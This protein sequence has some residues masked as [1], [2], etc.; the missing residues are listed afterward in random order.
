MKHRLWGLA[1]AGF[2]LLGTSG[3]QAADQTAIR[4][5]FTHTER[6]TD[7]VI[8][9]TRFLID[10]AQRRVRGVESGKDFADIRIED[11][12]IGFSTQE[13]G[14][15]VE[16]YAINRMTGL[17]EYRAVE[18][19]TWS[20]TCSEAAKTTIRANSRRGRSPGGS[21]SRREL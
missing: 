5:V 1:L 7:P 2:S 9:P 4:C 8:A 17:L 16:R 3:V 10:Y 19:A 14:R 15:G 18:D 21:M 11:N 6:G 12:S 20:G 13:P